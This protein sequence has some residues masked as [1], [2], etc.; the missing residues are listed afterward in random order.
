MRKI[1]GMAAENFFILMY[2]R[3][4]EEDEQE[5]WIQAGMYVL[6]RTFEEHVRFLKQNATVIP[7]KDLPEI[8]RG[9]LSAAGRGKPICVLTFDDGWTDFYTNVFPVLKHYNV[10]ATV[11]LPT[12]F[13]GSKGWFWTDRLACLLSGLG[14]AYQ[15]KQLF[16]FSKSNL[17]DFVK[18]LQGPFGF[19]LEAAI[20]HFKQH[21]PDE[22]ETA[23]DEMYA[24]GYLDTNLQ[25][26]AFLSWDEARE[27]RQTGLVNFGSHT[28]GHRIMT[29]L[30]NK[31]I[32]EELDKSRK[33]LLHEDCADPAFIPFCYPNG[34]NNDDIAQMVN[35][36]GY[37]LAVTTS[38]GWNPINFS[39]FKLK[40]IGM[41]QDMSST[42]A[43]FGCRLA[44][45]I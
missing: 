10:P 19:R 14:T 21:H 30:D 13:I 3:V 43:M 16:P 7:I 15:S 33:R 38:T 37:Q 8:S 42:P 9:N 26:R 40:R 24:E 29:L 20:A 5:E 2:H 35:D 6:R 12:D 18:N 28:C 45:L 25:E 34:N 44:S 17:T 39:L 23:L 4:L 32:R 36:A 41:H 27:M 1:Q 22:I 31:E 11:F